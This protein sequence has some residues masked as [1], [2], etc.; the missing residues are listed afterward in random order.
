MN[1]AEIEVELKMPYEELSSYLMEK[2]GSAL[3]DYFHTPEC[4]SK[5]KKVT[6]TSEGLYCHHI[7]EDKGG[8]LSESSIAIRQPFEWQRKERLVYCN[9]LEHL[10]LHIKIAVLRQKAPLKRPDDISG[11]FTTGGIYMICA[12]INDMFM[13]DATSIAWKKRCF[14]EIK[15]NYS[16]Y[17]TLLKALIN[18][19]RDNYIGEKNE[20]S[21]SSFVA[22]DA[23]ISKAPK[24]DEK[25]FRNILTLGQPASYASQFD[26]VVKKL[27]SGCE[28]FYSDIFD[29]IISCNDNNLSAKWQ[30]YF[31]IDYHGY[32]FPQLSDIELDESF[33]SRNADEYISKAL[34]MYSSVI[35]DVK[36][37]RVVFWKGETI[38]KDAEKNFYII[39]I[40][41]AFTVK[42]GMVPFVR[43][44]ERDIFR[45]SFSIDN[46]H[47][48]KDRGCI[49]LS[50][51]DI[52]DPETNRFYS[53]YTWRGKIKDATVKLSLGKDDYLLFMERYNI[54]SIK[55]LDGCYFC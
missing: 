18:Y 40:E 13:R 45:T 51:S 20:N 46:N 34:P 4:K 42:E 16:D 29:S 27:S 43:Y 21:S 7:D 32:G 48:F 33:G 35:N 19:I 26:T 49:V 15:E 12:D 3:Y 6:R 44:R 24:D 39:R 5:N 38:P 53:K 37:K 9:I 17:I 31:Y 36:G 55:I 2:Y 22:T 50:T 47:N 23:F 52:F 1:R 11:F 14:E 41:T 10:I 28:D 30:S 54:R 25:A 8:C